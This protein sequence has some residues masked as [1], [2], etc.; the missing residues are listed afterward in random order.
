MTI[1]N[2]AI[3]PITISQI[4]VNAKDFKTTGIA[5]P[6]TLAPGTNATMTVSF[7]PRRR[8]TSRGNITVAST[9][10]ASAVIPVTG[11]AVQPG[12]TVTPST[13]SFGNVTVG[14]PASQTIQLTNSG[15]GTLT[16]SQVSVAGTGFSAS[17]VSLP[18]TLSAG[19]STNF[20]VQFG[21]IFRPERILAVSPL[22]A[23]LQILPPWLR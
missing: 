6:A 1:T 3:A 17:A 7:N 10:G 19:Q 16:M 14:S 8:R 11:S 18:I 4:T 21:P 13:A 5:T 9:Q 20:N 2:A 12:L 22:S 23:T 15:T